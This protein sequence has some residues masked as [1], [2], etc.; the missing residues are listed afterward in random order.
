MQGLPNRQIPSSREKEFTQGD[1]SPPG[2]VEGRHDREMIR[3]VHGHGRVDDHTFP[4]WFAVAD[5]EFSRTNRV[6]AEEC[7]DACPVGQSAHEKYLF[8]PGKE[9]FQP[10]GH[11]G[12][13]PEVDVGV[14]DVG[15]PLPMPDVVVQIKFLFLQIIE[16]A[17]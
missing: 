16:Q 11:R 10:G 4:R 9:D 7:G 17:M 3:V 8:V 1:I 15:E 2:F 6:I 13:P 14:P 12:F 5:Q